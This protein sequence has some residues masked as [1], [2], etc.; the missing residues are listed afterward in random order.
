MPP[1][2]AASEA[3]QSYW[4][5]DVS[6]PPPGL[7]SRPGRRHREETARL[8]RREPLARC[9]CE[10]SRCCCCLCWRRG[11]PL[12][13]LLLLLLGMHT[14]P[15]QHLSDRA[16]L[17]AAVCGDLGRPGG[18]AR[19]A[20]ARLEPCDGHA[21]DQFDVILECSPAAASSPPSPP[22]FSTCAQSSPSRSHATMRTA[23]RRTAR[24]GELGAAQWTHDRQYTVRARR[25][26]K[27][28]RASASF[29]STT[30]SHR[31]ARCAPHADT[32][33]L[34]AR[35]RRTAWRSR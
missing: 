33:R 6:P 30:R 24:K 28:S 15:R 4:R 2:P 1:P 13:L 12:L 20:L 34:A 11:R 7:L 9:G 5:H 22:G 8:P 35:R 29:C 32:A 3:L 26:P 16:G 27:R 18:A 19:V 25:H 10:R 21:V 23:S 31:A 14:L 17:Q